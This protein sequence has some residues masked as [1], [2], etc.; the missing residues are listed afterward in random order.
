MDSVSRALA[1][2]QED[3]EA[4]KGLFYDHDLEPPL[5]A[6]A[7]LDCNAQILQLLLEH[8]ADVSAVNRQGFTAIAVLSALSCD[9]S[10]VALGK[11]RQ[12]RILAVAEMFINAGADPLKV[13]VH[14]QSALDLAQTG[15]NAHLVKLFLGEGAAEFAIA[16]A[17]T[18]KEEDFLT[19]CNAAGSR[20]SADL[21]ADLTAA[22][23]LA[24]MP[25][26]PGNPIGDSATGGLLALLS[27]P[28]HIPKLARRYGGC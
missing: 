8:G 12:R 20:F 21:T 6:A 11:G 23:L 13:E 24:G 2:C 25:M 9:A 10:C 3:P 14:G 22:G 19:R 26:P 7:R 27:R 17:L 28:R 16:E 15:G 18:T 4:A 1:A 5:C